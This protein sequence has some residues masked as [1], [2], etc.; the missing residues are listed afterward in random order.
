ML[1]GW[2]EKA[3]LCAACAIQIQETEHLNVTL[4]SLRLQLVATLED[5][6]KAKTMLE[7]KHKVWSFT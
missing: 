1:T 4:A 2:S 6:E 7:A 3:N 5:A